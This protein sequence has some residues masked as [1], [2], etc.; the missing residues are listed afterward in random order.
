MKGDLE[1]ERNGGSEG[2]RGREGDLSRAHSLILHS[3][4]S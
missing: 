2:G 3:A 4:I 1:G